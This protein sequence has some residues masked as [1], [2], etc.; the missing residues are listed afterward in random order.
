MKCSV[1]SYK[2]SFKKFCFINYFPAKLIYRNF[3]PF[4]VV[5]RYRDPK[6]Q[7]AE[8]DS[9]LFNLLYF[10]FYLMFK[11]SFHSQ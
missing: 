9:Y 8:N 7:V 2:K 5:S 1:I 3:K 4:E 10:Y 6:F 11:Q